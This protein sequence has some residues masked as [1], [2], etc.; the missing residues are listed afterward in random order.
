[1][2]SEAVSE[3]FRRLSTGASQLTERIPL[4]L[5]EPRAY[6]REAMLLA[7]IAALGLV[8]LL[9]IG[10]AAQDAIAAAIQRRRLGLRVRRV[11]HL[12]RAAVVVVAV[13]TALVSVLLLPL[14]PF[15]A[16]RGCATCHDVV[17]AVESW[18]TS[19]HADIGCYGCHADRGLLGALSAGVAG[20]SRRIG[21]SAVSSGTAEGS[22]PT[23][24]CFECHRED[25][26]EVDGGGDVIMCHENVVQ[27]GMPCLACHEGMGHARTVAEDGERGG[28]SMMT[29][30]L[31]C[32]DDRRAS[33]ECVTCH[34]GGRPL[35]TAGPGETVP[36]T[37]AAV[38]C[39]GC[40]SPST[41]AACIDC[42][43]LELPHPPEFFGQHAGRSH[44]DPA[45][46]T[47]C[48]DNAS[49]A[50]GC[51]CHP[52][53]GT[54]GT[55]T[56]WHPRHGVEFNKSGAGACGCHDRTFCGMCH[57]ASPL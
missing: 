16:E 9:L 47:R 40:H 29:L 46:C 21:P 3:F 18:R 52:D 20:L 27:A 42:H 6:P 57:P 45:L 41:A 12:K 8:V 36:Q 34:P 1:M 44:S 28:R 19:P 25:I 35:D 17:P 50:D 26:A 38:T 22:S 10:F 56:E 51:A 5:S 13:V 54:H 7:A 11:G 31:T 55:Y 14:V 32:H 24:S 33:A 15:V 4:V 43:G 37:P 30:C 2:G 49:R 48:H 53:Q 23:A 39:R